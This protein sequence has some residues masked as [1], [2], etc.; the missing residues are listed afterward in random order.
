MTAGALEI[1]TAGDDR[2]PG[3]WD[4][5]PMSRATA[6]IQQ[7]AMSWFAEQV[8]AGRHSVLVGRSAPEGS[9]PPLTRRDQPET[10]R[11]LDGEVTFY[12]GAE[13]VPATRGDVVVCP[14]GVPRT[15]RVESPGTE[16]QVLTSVSSLDRFTDFSRAV[17][18]PR[19]RAASD[20]PS[21]AELAAVASMAAANGI[22]L[23]G[24]PGALP[25]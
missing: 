9:M 3:A 2:A 7:A 21:P 16:W 5:L 23:M 18:R 15:F 11:V 10:Y 24:P 17:A 19:P 25:D 14:A 22:E 4:G 20:W 8:A 1:L 6:E 13:V 12:V